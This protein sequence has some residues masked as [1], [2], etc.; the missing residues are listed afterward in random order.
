MLRRIQTFIDDILSDEG[1]KRSLGEDEV[2][3]ACAALLVHCAR[4]DGH[5]SAEEVV[6]LRQILAD[7]Y[8]LTEEETQSLIEVAEQREADAVDVHRFT[9]LLHNHLD[10]DGRLE[11]IRLLWEI[12]HAD[13]SI[14]H[15]ERS[16]VNLVAGLLDVELADAVALRRSVTGASG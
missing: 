12:S 8:A 15:D 2:R 9:W 6:T 3:V 16:L 4:A 5:Q 11:V 14:D 7:R 10:R 1:N 13:S